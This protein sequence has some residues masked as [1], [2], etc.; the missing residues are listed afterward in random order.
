MERCALIPELADE[1]NEEIGVRT[2]RRKESFASRDLLS[3][4]WRESSR[5]TEERLLDRNLSIMK[6]SRVSNLD[7]SRTSERI[8]SGAEQVGGGVSTESN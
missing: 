2:A 7:E 4:E 6:A 5:S 8:I 1:K 3:D